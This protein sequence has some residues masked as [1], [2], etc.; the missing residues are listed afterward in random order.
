M[1]LKEG[2]VKLVNGKGVSDQIEM[3]REPFEK[4]SFSLS[5]EWED[6]PILLDCRKPQGRLR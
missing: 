2:L 1:Y 6:K 5:E 3:R 4:E